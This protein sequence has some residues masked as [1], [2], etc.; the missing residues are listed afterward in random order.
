VVMATS[1]SSYYLHRLLNVIEATPGDELKSLLD[2]AVY[3]SVLPSD[4]TKLPQSEAIANYVGLN[5]LMRCA[6][7]ANCAARFPD[8]NPIRTLTD[9]RLE[10]DN[11]SNTSCLRKIG[12]TPVQFAS[13]LGNMLSVPTMN[14]VPA[15]IFRLKRCSDND[16]RSF[17]DHWLHETANQPLEERF[18]IS[19]IAEYINDFSELWFVPGSATT[20]SEGVSKSGC[21]WLLGVADS[22]L[23]GTSARAFSAEGCVRK[24]QAAGAFSYPTDEFYL[25]YPSTKIPLLLMNGDFDPF[26]AMP[27]AKHSYTRLLH[28]GSTKVEFIEVP[29]SGHTPSMNSPTSYGGNCGLDLALSFAVSPTHTPELSCLP[30]ILPHNFDGVREMN[31]KMF[32][33]SDAW[34]DIM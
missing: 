7:D 26:I 12:L 21:G 19:I 33:Y 25:K 16:V 30:K 6:Q 5:L 18:G 14:L 13:Q 27:W 2:A 22:A 10:Y 28:A 3:D 31:L 4:V 17:R 32:G 8:S 1:Q 34:D 15:A 23:F 20:A 11:P 24:E 29:N 9:L